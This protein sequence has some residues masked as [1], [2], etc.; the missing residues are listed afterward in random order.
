MALFSSNEKDK[1]SAQKVRPTVVKT[2]NVAREL[3]QIAHSHNIK[4]EDLDFNLLETTTY[5]RLVENNDNE[6]D[7]EWMEMSQQ[8]LYELDDATALLNPGFEI[9]QEHE[10][11]IFLKKKDEG[12]YKNFKLAVGANAT[13]CKV[14]LTISAGSEVDY[15]PNFE[16]ELLLLI[17]KRKVRSGILINIFDEMIDDVVSKISAFVRVSQHA[18]YTK[19][20]TLLIAESYEP[21]LTINDA[22]ILHFEKKEE[23]VDENKKVDYSSRGFIKNVKKD[24][25]LIEYRKGK[26]GKAGRSC[27]GIFIKPKE[28]IIKYQPTFKVDETIKEIETFDNIQYIAVINGYISFEDNKYAIK[29]DVDLGEISFK[30]TGSI[31]TGLDSDVSV[32]VKEE[33]VEK[34]A[35]GTGMVVEVSEI[36]IDGNVGPNA[37]VF[38]LK[39]TIAGQTH[40]TSTLRADNLNINIHRGNAYGKKVKITRIEHGNVDCNNAEIVQ[41]IGGTIRANKIDINLCG[42]HVRA[43]ASRVI[44]IKKMQG[45]ENFFTIDPLLKKSSRQG[46][47]ENDGEL[48][49][50]EFELKEIAEEVNKYT[51]LIKDGTKSFIEIKKRLLHYKKNKI[52]MPDSFVKKYKQFQK[53]QLHLEELQKKHIQKKK[54]Y[55][56]L[57]SNRGSFQDDILDARIINRSRWVG[58]NELKFK[59]VDPPMDIVYYPKDG[60]YDQVFGLVQDMNGNYQVQVMDEE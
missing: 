8:N 46:L 20:E 56:Y 59:L 58:H 53:M 10:V 36:N 16:K 29:N 52:K 4:V 32:S 57:S 45:S 6:M 11:E 50:L 3:L 18:V 38:A 24:E 48:K 23:V 2:Q 25:L 49:E 42:S 28:P 15:T 54:E 9:K 41:A 40:K 1:D 34:D 30:T 37:K 31:S 26:L 7:I 60:S 14:Y 5:T 19:K 33:D 35:I 51:K 43:T 27:R 22:L 44:E 13:K 21:K 17:N 12:P 55:T 47:T 39:A